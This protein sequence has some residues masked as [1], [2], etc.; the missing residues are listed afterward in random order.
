MVEL[1]ADGLNALLSDVHERLSEV[2]TSPEKLRDLLRAT[3]VVGAGLELDP[4]LQ[5]IVQ[6]AT[7]LLGARYGALGVRAPGGGL[8]EFVYEGIDAGER[9]T[10]GHL[11]EGRGLLGLLIDDPRPVRIRELDR[12]AASVGFP[13]NHPPMS[14]FLGVPIIV[15][16][17][18][19]GS[20]YLTEKRD[21]PEFTDEDEVILTVLAESAALAVDNARLFEES[22]TRERWLR[23]VA[24][25]NSSLLIGG[26]VPETLDL[27]VRR[28]RELTSAESVTLLDASSGMAIVAATTDHPRDNLVADLA[29]S[30]VEEALRTG[31]AQ[32]TEPG[33]GSGP[34]AVLPVS[35][36]QHI[37]GALVVALGAGAHPWKPDELS[38]LAS[39]ADLAAVALEFAH[40]QRQQ[41]LLDVLADRDRIARDLHDNVIQRLFATGMSLQSIALPAPDGEVLARSVEQLDRT[42]REIRTTIFDLQTGDTATPAS[43]RRRLLD[44]I[45]EV[46]PQSAITPTVQFSGPIDTL[47]PAPVHPHAEAVLREGLS[48]ARRH[49]SAS[50]I[51]VSITAAEEFTIAITDDGVGMSGDEPRSG[52]ANLD[53]RAATC[54]GRCEVTAAVGGGTVLTWRVPMGAAG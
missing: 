8:S 29:G 48:N 27:L 23:A 46:T 30:P 14:S 25:I 31:R 50:S 19:F 41:R 1:P 17:R 52:L 53:R 15:R 36:P 40:R 28:V 51:A 22:R 18:A 21:A 26:S 47:V 10:M 45:G 49:A 44:V 20:I 38:R 13:P 16:G 54:A 43:L 24:A 4:T 42:V 6:A 5:R 39:M 32:L 33:S 34:A 3:L 35:G 12:H 2:V 9:A 7:Q 11:P 37:E